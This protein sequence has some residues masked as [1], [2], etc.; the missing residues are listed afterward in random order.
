MGR[1]VTRHTVRTSARRATA[2]DGSDRTVR[3]PGTIVDFG[4][5]SISGNGFGI[6]VE[7][8]TI[9]R[10]RGSVQVRLTTAAAAD[11]F[12]LFAFGLIVVSENAFGIGPTAMPDP[13]VDISDD[14]IVHRYGTVFGLVAGDPPADSV[15]SMQRFEIDSKAQRKMRVTEVLAWVFSGDGV[16]GDTLEGSGD[17]R[18]LAK[19]V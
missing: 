7:K 8:L 5:A 3:W 14:W 18:V 4:S 19:L 13:F 10:V 1:V 9:V 15:E 16:A 12:V 6:T 17:C 11:T 2:W